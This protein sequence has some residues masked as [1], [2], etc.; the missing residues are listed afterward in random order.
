M[1][2]HVDPEP[3]GVGGHHSEVDHIVLEFDSVSEFRA[4]VLSRIFNFQ[5]RRTLRGHLLELAM[6]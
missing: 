5:R 6:R 4:V 1:V 2:H 3:H